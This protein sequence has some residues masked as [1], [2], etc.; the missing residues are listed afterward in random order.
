MKNIHVKEIANGFIVTVQDPEYER[1]SMQMQYSARCSPEHCF[2]T[3]EEMINFISNAYPTYGSGEISNHPS[4]P[5]EQK[6]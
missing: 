4:G 1:A 2:K 5:V 6:E 3:K